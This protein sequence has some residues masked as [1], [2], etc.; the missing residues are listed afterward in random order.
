[1]TSICDWNPLDTSSVDVFHVLLQSMLQKG[2]R[3]AHQHD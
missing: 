1:M 2:S 3:N